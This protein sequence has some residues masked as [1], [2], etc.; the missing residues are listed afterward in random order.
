MKI[1]TLLYLRHDVSLLQPWVLLLLSNRYGC[2]PNRV[3][4]WIQADGRN[5]S[6]ETQLGEKSPDTRLLDQ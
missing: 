1:S 4:G 2:E 3:A 6:R 5:P